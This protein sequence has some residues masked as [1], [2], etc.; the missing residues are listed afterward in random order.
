M[1][2]LQT[3]KRLLIGG[4]MLLILT[5][6]GFCHAGDMLR[7]F[8]FVDGQKVTA[9]QLNGLVDNGSVLSS[10]YTSK[11]SK[12]NLDATDLVLVYDV[13]QGVYRKISGSAFLLNN[14]SWISSLSEGTS[15]ENSDFVP[16]L[17][18]SAGV[19]KKAAITNLWQFGNQ[20]V[21]TPNQLFTLLEWNSGTGNYYQLPGLTLYTNLATNWGNYFVLTNLPQS[22]SLVQASNAFWTFNAVTGT[23]EYVLLSQITTNILGTNGIVCATTNGSVQATNGFG[24][25]FTNN[26]IYLSN[27]VSTNFS[28]PSS[29]QVWTNAHSL[30]CVPQMVRAV[31]VC[32]NAN[33]SYPV[34]AEIDLSGIIQNSSG[35]PVANISAD[36]TNTYIVFSG[37][38]VAAWTARPMNTITYSNITPGSWNVKIYA[39][40]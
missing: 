37:T 12:T 22:T 19:L 25:G 28:V 29:S 30:G 13:S 15:L 40:P 33:L 6:A 3:C 17:D 27:F 16:F 23:N 4:V 26:T 9:A 5:L 8:N 36:S 14:T 21:A 34:G 11:S 24:V 1:I 7:G 2:E 18:V 35:N 20:P 38:G 39:R 10:F 32:T 31:L